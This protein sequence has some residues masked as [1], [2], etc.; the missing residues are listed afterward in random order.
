MSDRLPG[1]LASLGTVVPVVTLADAALA[2]PLADA[3]AGGGLTSVEITLRTPAGLEAIERL[4]DRHDLV[5]G[6]GTVVNRAGAESA[7]AAGAAFLVGPGF[8]EGVWEVGK[9]RGVPVV[10]GV[11]TATELMRV[12]AAGARLVKFFPAVAAG[13]LPAVRALAAVFPDVSFMVTGGITAQDAGSWLAE[14]SVVAVGGSW[15]A[16]AALLREHR[17][18]TITDLARESARLGAPRDLENAA[19][20]GAAS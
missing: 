14:S 12:V 1:V 13:G 20:T 15:I 17:F 3:L 6:A 10:P 2:V 8:D 7:V 16:P 4:A 11:A 19:R 18:G 5:V 9:D